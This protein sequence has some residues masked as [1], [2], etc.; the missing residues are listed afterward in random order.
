VKWAW[1]LVLTIG[2]AI[3]RPKGCDLAQLEFHLRT[4]HNPT[5][6]HRFALNWILDFGNTCTTEQLTWLWNNSPDLMGT[7]DTPEWRYR[8][9]QASENK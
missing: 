4:I 7:A 8:L 3:A 5:E 1:V 9:S 6:R 2:L